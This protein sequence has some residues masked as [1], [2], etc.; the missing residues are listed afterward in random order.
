MNLSGP[1]SESRD[2]TAERSVTRRLTSSHGAETE[3]LV[4][5]EGDY[6]LWR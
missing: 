5:H 4:N 6:W 3:M 2:V 1:C